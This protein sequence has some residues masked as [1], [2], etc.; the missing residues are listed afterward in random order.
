[1]PDVGGPSMDGLKSGERVPP[2]VELPVSP[3]EPPTSDKPAGESIPVATGEAPKLDNLEQPP[4]NLAEQAGR[5]A[6][7]TVSQTLPPVDSLSK[8][9]DIVRQ[10]PH[11]LEGNL[12]K[13]SN[14]EPQP[15]APSVMPEIVSAPRGEEYPVPEEA[16]L[17]KEDT[18]EVMKL[19]ARLDRIFGEGMSLTEQLR[20]NNAGERG[21]DVDNGTPDA[22][23]T[24]ELK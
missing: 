8:P 3:P 17:D 12:A 7:E 5:D 19:L 24:Q 4:P 15:E 21:D 1:M 9:E 10:E 22:T 11:E 16:G 23:E 14:P 6:A 20:R 18:P 2:A 13:N